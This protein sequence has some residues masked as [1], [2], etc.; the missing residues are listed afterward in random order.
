MGR[1]AEQLRF[2]GHP[3]RHKG[4]FIPVSARGRGAKVRR[5]TIGRHGKL[6]PDKAQTLA[7]GLALR[8]AQGIDPQRLKVEEARE[9]IDLAFSSYVERFAEG[10]L[11]V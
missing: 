5:Y 3:V 6:T 2:E 4:L 1:Q 8:T 9:A 7:E 11:R 10:C